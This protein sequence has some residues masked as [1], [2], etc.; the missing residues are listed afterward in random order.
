MNVPSVNLTPIRCLYNSHH[1]DFKLRPTWGGC[2]FKTHSV[3]HHID[4]NLTPTQ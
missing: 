1:V 2:G 4:V 3:T